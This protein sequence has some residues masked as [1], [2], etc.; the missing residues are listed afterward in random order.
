MM[1][2]YIDISDKFDDLLPFGLS[3]Q[4]TGIVE[5]P[6]ADGEEFNMNGF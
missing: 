1:N 3:S 6:P 2:A 4:G 5:W